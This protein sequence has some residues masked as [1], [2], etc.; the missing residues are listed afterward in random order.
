MK[1]IYVKNSQ[2]DAKMNRA[3]ENPMNNL[4]KD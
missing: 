2:N 1:K 3:Q 4:N